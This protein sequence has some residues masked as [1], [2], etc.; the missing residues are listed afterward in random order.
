M[1]LCECVCVCVS[2]CMCVRVCVYVRVYV[3]VCVCVCV[4]LSCAVYTGPYQSRW[5]LTGSSSVLLQQFYCGFE[6]NRTLAVA[7]ALGLEGEQ[8]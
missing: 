8:S 4:Q 2:V 7:H 5:T 6:P 1:C 3:R